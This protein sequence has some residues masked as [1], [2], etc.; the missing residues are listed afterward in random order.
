MSEKR[1]STAE[2][3]KLAHGDGH[4]PSVALANEIKRALRQCIEDRKELAETLL[5]F[6]RNDLVVLDDED[7]EDRPFHNKIK[8]YCK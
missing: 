4:A 8:E 5:D 1:F 6:E 2:M 7:E 3:R